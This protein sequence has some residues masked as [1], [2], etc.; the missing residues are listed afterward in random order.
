MNML[1]SPG[2]ERI[3]PAIKITD[4]GTD[5]WVGQ[6]TLRLRREM[7]W[8]RNLAPQYVDPAQTALDLLRH[9]QARKTFFATD[10]TCRY[11]EDQM[12]L[13][14]AKKRSVFSQM[15]SR[16]KLT[17]AECFVL[18]LTIAARIDGAMGPV[19]AAC[20]NDAE[21]PW[22]TLALA[23]SLWEK[24]LAVLAAHELTRPLRVFGLLAPGSGV[25]LNDALVPCPGLARF[26][27]TTTDPAEFGLSPITPAK[28]ADPAL[29]PLAT[30]LSAAPDALEIIP[31]VGPARADSPGLMAD[32][33]ALGARQCV[34]SRSFSKTGLHQV[35]VLAWLMQADVLLSQHLCLPGNK[36]NSLRRYGD[37]R[38]NYP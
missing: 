10:P 15:A 28:T 5:W 30:R 14:P 13:K 36:L 9:D 29:Q 8:R 37:W 1:S 25:A 6:A 23:Q 2:P 34:A 26:L 11:L 21:R 27:C 18:G 3:S 38:H 19:F 32:L 12:A 20:Q 33:G 24:P 16:A 22:P 4:P 17:K 31:L 35:L 7:A